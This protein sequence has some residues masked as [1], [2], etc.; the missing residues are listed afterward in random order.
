MQLLLTVYKNIRLFLEGQERVEVNKNPK[1]N[2]EKYFE[3]TLCTS[4]TKAVNLKYLLNN[5]QPMTVYGKVNRAGRADL[6]TVGNK[7]VMVSSIHT[8]QEQ[9]LLEEPKRKDANVKS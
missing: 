4:I 3:T 5:R 8:V 2:Q 6:W 7:R 9:G 1:R